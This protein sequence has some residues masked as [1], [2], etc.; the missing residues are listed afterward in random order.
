MAGVAVT[1]VHPDDTTPAPAPAVRILPPLPAETRLGPFQVQLVLRRL[2][3]S[4]KIGD[5]GGAEPERVGGSAH[6]PSARSRSLPRPRN[7]LSVGA[8]AHRHTTKR[9][10]EC[11]VATVHTPGVTRTPQL[12]PQERARARGPASYNLIFWHRFFPMMS[13]RQLFLWSFGSLYPSWMRRVLGPHPGDQ[14]LK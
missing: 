10:V 13:C 11:A 7:R 3:E 4:M 9:S 14:F 12:S 5:G 8:F 6:V 1:D 2:V